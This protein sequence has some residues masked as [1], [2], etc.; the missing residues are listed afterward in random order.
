MSWFGKMFSK[1]EKKEAEVAVSKDDD[2]PVAAEEADEVLAED[3]RSLLLQLI[4]ANGLSMGMDLSKVALPT[5]I[6]EP[7]SLL[8]KL[9]DTV[10]HPEILTDIP[11]KDTPEA[12]MLA[13]VRWYMSAYHVRPKGT[14]KPFNPVLGET[15]SAHFKAAET[16]TCKDGITWTAQ[17]VSH[18]PPV[19]AF[20]ARD[21][22]GTVVIQG[23]FAPKSKF[24]GNS[25]ASMGGGAFRIYLPQHDEVYY[26]NWPSVYVRG[27][28]FGTLLMEV[29]GNVVIACPK[30]NLT[31]T[32]DFQAKGF[33]GGAYHH[34]AGSV[35]R[36]TKAE[37][38]KA[39]KVYEI[40]GFWTGKTTYKHMPDGETHTLF[41]VAT[42]PLGRIT[43]DL[44]DVAIAANGGPNEKRDEL[45]KILPSRATWKPVADAIAA[46][47]QD[48]ATSCKQ[49][50]EQAQRDIRAARAE[51]GQTFKPTLFEHTGED[52]WEYIG[53]NAIKLP[54]VQLS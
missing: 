25:A 40:S 5:F 2:K 14:K 20:F 34:V 12:R 39:E 24:L 45:H 26:L 36:G 47:D 49:E 38:K 4:S 3:N 11:Q 53:P 43:D 28:L 7:R 10:I 37:Q 16:T 31:A 27:V 35:F 46:K 41:D 9:S 15:F 22:A 48:T 33:F 19:S 52:D 23:C 18:H 21:D 17:Q 1:G 44:T 54:H 51:A 30:N 42:N 8:E 32:L 6:L 50:I 29:A 13:V